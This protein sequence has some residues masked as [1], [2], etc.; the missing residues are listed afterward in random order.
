MNVVRHECFYFRTND[1]NREHY[2]RYFSSQVVS[3]MWT[4][5]SSVKM[6]CVILTTQN[7]DL[8]LALFLV[9]QG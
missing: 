7:C 6:L 4:E 9:N 5:N 3:Q 8:H 2:T 1:I